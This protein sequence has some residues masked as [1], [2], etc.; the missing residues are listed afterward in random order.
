[1]LTFAD[2]T[3]LDTL[4]LRGEFVAMPGLVITSAQAARLLG[5]RVE[6]AASILEGLERE[7]FLVRTADGSFR[8][9]YPLPT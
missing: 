2:A 8:R 9:R 5:V 6:R 4:R 3:D 1:M 7:G